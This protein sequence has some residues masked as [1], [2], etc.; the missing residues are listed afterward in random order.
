VLDYLSTKAEKQT[1]SYHEIMA[2]IL[3][4]VN[5]RHPVLSAVTKLMNQLVG[6]RYW[7]VQEICHLLDILQQRSRPVISVDC[8]P[9]R[10]QADAYGFSEEGEGA[11]GTLRK[12]LSSFEKYKRRPD[13]LSSLSYL[14]FLKYYNFTRFDRITKR[15]GNQARILMYFPEYKLSDNVED[16]TCAASSFSS[17]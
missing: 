9:E 13:T 15:R 11:G 10:E 8:R 3:P 4:S 2:R 6:E 14:E 16:F 7:S 17:G 1:E 12:G 5:S